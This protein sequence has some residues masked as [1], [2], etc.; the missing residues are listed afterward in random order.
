MSQVPLASTSKLRPR[1]QAAH[2]WL[3]VR[4]PVHPAFAT[5]FS[6]LAPSPNAIP[7][8]SE[9]FPLR[10]SLFSAALFDLCIDFSARRPFYRRVGEITKTNPQVTDL[11]AVWPLPLEASNLCTNPKLPQKNKILYSLKARK[12]TW[13]WLTSSRSPGSRRQSPMRS[14]FRTPREGAC[15]QR[16]PG[17]LLGAL[18][19]KQIKQ[20][21]FPAIH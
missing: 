3:S 10:L 19:R 16:R 9:H 12:G 14:R 20:R 6:S 15:W 2:E 7:A 4:R 13:R 11:M 18:F 17:V 21:G 8:H 1:V 5:A